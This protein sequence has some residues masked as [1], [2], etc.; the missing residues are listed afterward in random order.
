ME[1]P[2]R[3]AKWRRCGCC[4][5][6]GRWRNTKCGCSLT[7][8]FSLARSHG[9]RLGTHLQSPTQEQFNDG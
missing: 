1:E 5:P 2:W 3:N 6:T 9:V 7:G 8:F 4:L